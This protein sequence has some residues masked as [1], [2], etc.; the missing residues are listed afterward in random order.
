MQ[1]KLMKT[2]LEVAGM[3][4]PSASSLINMGRLIW[5]ATTPV[6]DPGSNISIT[7][8]ALTYISDLIVDT[9]HFLEVHLY[10]ITQCDPVIS[11]SATWTS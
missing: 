7:Q 8:G 9:I 4:E 5:R 2:S 1:M 10:T 11:A 3:Q 6:K